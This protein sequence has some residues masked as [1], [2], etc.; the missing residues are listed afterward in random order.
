VR[1]FTRVR[2]AKPEE[3]PCVQ[4]SE[5]SNSVRILTEIQAPVT[6]IDQSRTA[7]EAQDFAF[8]GVFSGSASQE[9]VF[10]AVGQP[11]LLECLAGF[12]GTI[13]AYGQTGSG[14]THSLLES[15]EAGVLPRLACEL[16]AQIAQDA[17]SVYR[18]E[19]AAMQVY[20][21]QVDDLLHLSH[22]SGG[23]RNLPLLFSGEVTEL[24]WVHCKQSRKLLNTFVKARRNLIYAETKM[25]KASS[26]SHAIFQIRI[27]KHVQ[28]G[29]GQS[30]CSRLN[31][32]DLAG[33]ERIK[34][35]GAQG[36]QFKE[37]ININN[38][39][40]TLGNVVSA[41]ATKK[42][43]IPYRDSKLTH[44][45]SSSLGQNCKTTLL[46]CLSPAEDHGHETLCSLKF[47]SRAMDIEVVAHVNHI[48]DSE[49]LA[50]EP[51]PES[52]DEAASREASREAS[53]EVVACRQ[54]SEE[55]MQRAEQAETRAAQASQ[56]MTEA[57]ER[58]EQ[59]EA[60][61]V[62]AEQAVAEWKS[63]AESAEL[64]AQEDSRDRA[65]QA[66]E[67]VD[68]WKE[69]HRQALL[70]IAQLEDRIAQLTKELELRGVT[71]KDLRAELATLR[72]E[73]QSN[74]A[75][76]KRRLSEAEKSGQ[77]AQ[78]ASEEAARLSA[79]LQ[80]ANA[81]AAAERDRAT[82][83]AERLAEERAQGEVLANRRL[84]AL[85]DLEAER[86]QVLAQQEE[87]QEQQQSLAQRLA[88]VE[89]LE[90]EKRVLTRQK[91]EMARHRD[92]LQLL[93]R[94]VRNSLGSQAPGPPVRVSHE[95]RLLEKRGSIF[96][97]ASEHILGPRQAGA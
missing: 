22:N 25:N 93:D 71:I 84:A 67:E 36:V 41:L 9:D 59:S 60:R 53:K 39:L 5:A 19:A 96:R 49:T 74:E 64:A 46:V 54:A 3:K 1:V 89:G 31:V 28:P 4:P 92:A 42:S 80:Q 29:R 83:E 34:K 30:T 90:N 45:L 95:I 48:P 73:M 14:K 13:L 35:S 69:S 43:F 57:V 40:L 94:R 62:L 68:A 81:D 72:A 88:A 55:A 52:L 38:S 24:T 65:D 47:A 37:A 2:P 50:G 33:S 76:I 79:E 15:G 91:E 32:V 7:V 87:L 66:I 26:R 78:A 8:D 20:N 11:V 17:E 97:A 51:G 27:T 85:H 61:A 77:E 6:E 12:N 58:A 10:A 21:E 82:R 63:R 56:A 18:V 23:G 75:E 44:I 70:Q 86:R 16:F